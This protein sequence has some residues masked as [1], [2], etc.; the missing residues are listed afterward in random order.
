MADGTNSEYNAIVKEDSKRMYF[1]PNNPLLPK[2]KMFPAVRPLKE[3]T[4]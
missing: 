2:L 1:D 4:H 3:L